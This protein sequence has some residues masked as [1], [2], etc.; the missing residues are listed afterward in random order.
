[1]KSIDGK[2]SQAETQQNEGDSCRQ[3]HTNKS[4]TVIPSLY[5]AYQVRS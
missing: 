1:M 2:S 3:G 5:L 4:C